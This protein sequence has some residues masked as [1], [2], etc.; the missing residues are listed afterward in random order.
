M[1]YV[2]VFIIALACLW[3]AFFYFT[4]T[5]R[6]RRIARMTLLFGSIIVL[7]LSALFFVTGHLHY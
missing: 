6:D 5:P 2:S 7:V 3:F 1:V 4:G